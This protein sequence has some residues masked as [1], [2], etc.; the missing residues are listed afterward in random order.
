MKSIIL[1]FVL[2]ASV[3]S[4]FTSCENRREIFWVMSTPE[5]SWQVQDVGSIMWDKGDAE[6]V[7]CYRRVG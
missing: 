1:S 3:C 5:F 4:V 6:A 7:V 2:S